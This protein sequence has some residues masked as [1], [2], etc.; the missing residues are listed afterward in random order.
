LSRRIKLRVPKSVPNGFYFLVACVDRGKKIKELDEANNCRITG[1]VIGVGQPLTGP[2]GPPGN[3]NQIKI[4]R[5]SLPI[6]RPTVQGVNASRPFGDDEKSN[7][8]ST[9]FRRGPIS[10]V[11]DCKRTTNGDGAGPDTAPGVA[12]ERNNHDEDGD[13]AKLLVYTSEGAVTFSSLGGSS[14]R[15]IGPGEGTSVPQDPGGGDSPGTALAERTGGEGKHMAVA[16]SRDPDQAFPE[17]DWATAFKVGSL[18]VAHSGGLEFTFNGYAGIDVLG[19][20]DR[21]VFGGVV[22]VVNG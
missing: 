16:A 12:G 18:Y 20:G 9:I 10:V 14:R 6:G 15:N 5:Q 7:V 22:T 2:A 19:V 21:C 13:E 8:R 11:A 1:Q 3:S 4:S 17:D